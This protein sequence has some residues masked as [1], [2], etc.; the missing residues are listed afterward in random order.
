M[1]N[2]S[3]GISKIRGELVSA[4]AELRKCWQ[5]TREQV[6]NWRK[7]K[8]SRCSGG[9]PVEKGKRGFWVLPGRT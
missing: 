8:R 5:N 1:Q 2:S 6:T 4:L 7:L 9:F 3:T